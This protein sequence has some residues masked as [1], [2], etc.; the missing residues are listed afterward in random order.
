M[1]IKFEKVAYVYYLIIYYSNFNL[2]LSSWIIS[3]KTYMPIIFE[4]EKPKELK[5]SL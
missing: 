3:K 4:L 2:M 5:F 1:V